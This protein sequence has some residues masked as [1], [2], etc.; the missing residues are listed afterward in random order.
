MRSIAA[1]V[2]T[3]A[4][5]GC[6]DTIFVNSIPQGGA[7][8][9]DGQ[10]MGK[11]PVSVEVSSDSKIVVKLAG[12]HDHRVILR[13]VSDPILTLFTLGIASN[14]EKSYAVRLN[15]L[16]EPGNAK[17][18]TPPAAPPAPPPPSPE[19]ARTAPLVRYCEECGG[20]LR[21]GAKFCGS[22]GSKR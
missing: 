20:A 7:V 9:V 19:P 14:L 3:V 13:E 22:C 17:P 10:D 1:A 8:S 6:T 11:T 16:D 15:P 18:A 12:Y 4:L 5:T 2:L 21:D